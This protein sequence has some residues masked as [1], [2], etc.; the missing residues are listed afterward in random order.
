MAPSAPPPPP[1]FYPTQFS[2]LLHLNRRYRQLLDKTVVYPLYRWLALASL[3]FLFA[4]RIWALQGWY[5]VTYGLGIFSLNLF[6][7]FI[8]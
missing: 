6:I 8:K 4:M 3:L 7:G 1:P 5:I 2:S